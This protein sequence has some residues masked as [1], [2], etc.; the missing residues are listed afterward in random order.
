[1]AERIVLLSIPQL[2]ARDVSPGGLA[3]LEALACRGTLHELVPAFPGTAASSF[4]TLVTGASPAEHGIVGDTYFD[5]ASRRVAAR[6][7]P[8]ADVQAPKLWERLRGVRPGATTL[9][10]FAPNSQG[11]AVEVN[12]WVDGSTPATRPEGLVEELVREFGP[13]PCPSGEAP[14][15]EATAWILRT[16]GAAIAAHPPDLAIVRVPYLGQVARRYGPDGRESGRAVRS[17]EGMLG[18]FLKGLPRESLVVAVT[19]SITTPV[20][21]PV[22]PNRILRDLGLLTLRSAEGGG[23]DICLEGSA[24]FALADHQVCHVYLNDP[25]QMGPVAAAFAGPRGDG[26]EQVAS[27]GQRAALGLDHPRSGDIILIAA[28][29]RWFAPDWWLAPGEAPR[30]ASGTHCGLAH[31]TA[32]GLLLDPARVQGSLGAPVPGEEYL[33]VVIASGPLPGLDPAAGPL[34][35]RDLAALVLDCAAHATPAGASK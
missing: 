1:M 31:A 17:L 20:S 32:G 33:G 23:M 8:D 18:A 28:P 16:A 11:A 24:A 4:A 14:T 13:Y 27:I 19:E 12:G 7:L 10:W 21:A 15:P 22:F 34:A 25:A 3:S 5:R 9:L 26:I 2:R 30:L 6:P 29:D 35:A